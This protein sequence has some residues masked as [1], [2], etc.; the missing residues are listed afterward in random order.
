MSKT[1]SDFHF[2]EKID[3]CIPTLSGK[4]YLE[5]I[6][7][8]DT[9]LP[10]LLEEENAFKVNDEE[11]KLIEEALLAENLNL[12]KTVEMLLKLDKKV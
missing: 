3:I 6:H 5:F 8:E 11:K 10:N 9:K 7:S 4:E 12:D 1:L 2:E